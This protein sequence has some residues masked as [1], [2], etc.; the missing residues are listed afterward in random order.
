[1]SILLPEQLDPLLDG[2]CR[3]LGGI[4]GLISMRGSFIAFK[5]GF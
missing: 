5:V 3:T 1:M 4:P 2:L